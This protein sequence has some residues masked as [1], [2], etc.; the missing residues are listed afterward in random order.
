[1]RQLSS[2]LLLLFINLGFAQVGIGTT[3]PQATLDISASNAAT[4]SNTDGLLIPRIDAFPTTN[5]T[6]NQ[7]AMLVYLTTTDGTDA[8]GFYYWNNTLTSWIPFSATNNAWD[9]LGNAGTVNGT[10]FLGTTDSQALDIRTNNIIHGRF[11]TDGKLEM[12]NAGNSVYIG[13]SAGSAD[14]TSVAK[15]NVMVGAFSGENLTTGATASYHGKFNTGLG[16]QAL[17]AATTA[18]N[19]IAIGHSAML[20]TTTGRFNTAIGKDAMKNALAVDYNTAIGFDALEN[21]AGDGNTG[22][23]YRALMGA[24]NS[25]ISLGEYNTAL[26]EGAGTRIQ[27]GSNNV[28]LGNNVD[29]FN[30]DG[31]QN[32]II[33]SNAGAAL[34]S[35]RSVSGRVLIGYRA[36][37]GTSG[38]DNTLMIE[39]SASV[40]P[41]LY[42]EFDNDI[43]RVG[44]Q[45]QIGSSDDTS[46]GAIYSFPIA[47]GT[48]GQ[49]LTTDGAGNVT[50]QNT[51]GGT[52]NAWDL[53]GNAGTV[54]GTNFLGTTDN[55]ALDI[56]TNNIIHGRFTTDGKLEMLNAGNSVYIGENA[57]SADPISIAKENVMI[58][59][60]SGENITTGASSI[61]HGKYNTGVGYQALNAE[62][63]GHRNTAIGHSAMLSITSG[64]FNTG[65]GVDA[66]RNAVDADYSTAVGNDALENLVGDGNTG[67]GYRALMGANNSTLSLGTYNTAIGNGAGRRIQDGS[68]NVWL[69]NN[70]DEFNIDGNQNTIIGS[71]A[72][73]VV[74]SPRSVNGRV[75]IGYRVG[76][77][78]GGVDNTLMIENSASTTPLIGGDF[79]ND[80]V[81]INIDING[82]TSNLTHTLTVGGSVKLSEVL[83]ITPGTAPTTPAEGDVYYDS[84]LK[85]L[86]VF[87]GS[88]WENLN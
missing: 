54:N 80:K 85:K 86:R 16:Y 30:T 49:V 84:T 57:G 5:P 53:L 87:T 9:L 23:G 77:G 70:V 39:N 2:I 40:T 4:P 44:G 65:I 52:G 17:N 22:V 32:T 55:Q 71:D 7:H 31:N 73:A 18:H 35:P 62:T 76:Y 45:L 50:W 8:P 20:S 24:N 37:F 48:S 38:V 64:R 61:Y 19:N 41:L 59:A 46:A 72:G 29:E 74:G 36:G 28:W 42:G 68:N 10:N 26:G 79:A 14:P 75:L 34:G 33:G 6:V 25:V 81:G 83:H 27:D 58:G 12:L 3:N 66:L 82:S 56:R 43:L 60:F 13:E 78:S 47:D 21:L 88:V 15:E 63:T 69:G 51:S 11:T 1:M 67:V